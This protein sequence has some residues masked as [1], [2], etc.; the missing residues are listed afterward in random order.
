MLEFKNVSYGWDERHFL[1]NNL[2]LKFEERKIY[3][4]LG[5]NGCGKS[6]FIQ[7]LQNRNVFYKGEILLNQKNL[8]TF[9][10]NQIARNLICVG[11]NN[12]QCINMKVLDFIVTG[13]YPYLNIFQSPADKHLNE[14][15]RIM[16]SLKIEEWSSRTIATLSG[17]LL[18]ELELALDYANQ[19]KFTRTVRQLQESGKCIILISHNP[20][21][22]L[23]LKSQ[24]LM[25]GKDLPYLFGDSEGIVTRENLRKYFN[26]EVIETCNEEHGLVQFVPQ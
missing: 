26:I 16:E 13:F 5:P 4:I 22:A 7:L 11:Q 23:A 20:N 25:F 24:V 3:V 15:M 10:V 8:N 17:I 6:T 19:I 18:D 12:D 21:L 2:N 14:A 1:Q 9:S